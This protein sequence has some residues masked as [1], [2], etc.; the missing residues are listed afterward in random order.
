MHI[1]MHEGEEG[2]EG[3]GGR[4]SGGRVR[5]VGTEHPQTLLDED[6]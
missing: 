6:N 1:N 3:G 2:E 4:G 5:L